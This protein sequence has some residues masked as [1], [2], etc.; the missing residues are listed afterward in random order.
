MPQH[1]VIPHRLQPPGKKRGGCLPTRAEKN[2]WISSHENP[3]AAGKG[4]AEGKER[5]R[6][7]GIISEKTN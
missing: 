3:A 5:R 7:M 2:I 4:K 1:K 6:R